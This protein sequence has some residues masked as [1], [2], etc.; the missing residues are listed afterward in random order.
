M[1][2][3]RKCSS[4]KHFPEEDTNVFYFNIFLVFS[5]LKPYMV[6]SKFLFFINLPPIIIA[7]VIEY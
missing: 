3:Y 2:F 4:L 6:L 1:R 7:T 5:Y